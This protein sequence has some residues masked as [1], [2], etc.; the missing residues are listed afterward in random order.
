MVIDT[1]ETSTAAKGIMSVFEVNHDDSMSGPHKTYVQSDNL[2]DHEVETAL[3]VT[4]G[5]LTPLAAGDLAARPSRKY[6]YRKMAEKEF[7]E[8]LKTR[9]MLHPQAT[10][11]KNAQQVART[12]EKWFTEAIEHS[13]A[14]NR[15]NAEGTQVVAEFEVDR[16]GYTRDIKEHSIEQHGSKARQPKEGRLFN[17]TNRERLMDHPKGKVNVGLKGVQNVDKFNE[18]VISVRKIDPHSLMN[19]TEALRWLRRNK[20]HV[21]G[22]A[23]GVILD[24]VSLILS[25]IDDGGEFGRST[26]LTTADIGGGALGGMIG[27]AIGS[28]LPGIGTAI[29]SFIGS[30]IGS[31]I[32][33]G[34]T[35]FFLSLTPVT[36][37]GPGPP[38][39]QTNPHTTMYGQPSLRLKTSATSGPPRLGV[40]A[41]KQEPPKTTFTVPKGAPKSFFNTK[42]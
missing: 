24:G 2:G 30:F 31:L 41:G 7:E 19:K 8:V 29:C 34:I 20:L 28:L 21:L 10:N 5:N 27:G 38:V 17:V 16:K 14:Y 42:Q 33:N 3:Q 15:S 39:L 13:R 9:G 1:V 22:G 35:R 36:Q 40:H 11:P 23:V 18:H 12:G 6:V 37:P 4:G 26:T 32:A 25:L